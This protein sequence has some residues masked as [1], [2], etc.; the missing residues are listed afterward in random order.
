MLARAVSCLAYASTSLAKSALSF[1]LNRSFAWSS[2][3]TW[4][5]RRLTAKSIRGFSG[6]GG[7]T[8]P[9]MVSVN[10]LP[11]RWVSHFLAKRSDKS[12]SSTGKQRG[13]YLCIVNMRASCRY[14]HVSKKPEFKYNYPLQN[15]AS[16]EEVIDISMKIFR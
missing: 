6:G 13:T 12:D 10:E 9:F 8:T 4:S 16:K 2:L 14:I 15:D 11:S 7:V 1:W 5:W 3:L